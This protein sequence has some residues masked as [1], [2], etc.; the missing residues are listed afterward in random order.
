MKHIDLNKPLLLAFFLCI[1]MIIDAQDVY[2]VGSGIASIEPDEDFFSQSLQGYGDPAEG[3]F[4][5]NW[6]EKGDIE[7][8]N[9]LTGLGESLY[10]LRPGG[11]LYKADMTKDIPTWKWVAA[12]DTV[13]RLSGSDP[14]SFKIIAGLGDKLYAISL[15]NRLSVYD[16]TKNRIE[17][18]VIGN[19]DDAI[20]LTGTRAK[21]YMVTSGYELLEGLPKNNSM[22]WKKK[23]NV[24]ADILSIT[25]YEDRLYMLNSSQWIWEASLAEESVSWRKIAYLNGITYK[26][27]VSKL[28][29]VGNKLYAAGYD[30][31]IYVSRNET[32]NN[33]S[34]RALAI[35]SRSNTV[36]LVGVDLA[37]IDYS[38]GVEVKKEI[39][40]QTGIPAEAVMLNMS[41]S[42]FT[43]T[44]K[45]WIPFG[46][47]GYPDP[48]YMEKVKLSIVEA[49]QQ[50]VSSLTDSH[51]YFARTETYIGFNRSLGKNYSHINDTDVDILK[52]ENTEGKL[53][54][55]LFL[56]GCHPVFPNSGKDGFTISANYPGTA[57]D[58]IEKNISGSFSLFLQGCS[59]D[60]N[61]RLDN[62]E[63]L[64]TVLAFDVLKQLGKPSDKISGK[65]TY[66]LDSLLVPV[67]VWKHDKIESFRNDNLNKTGDI[68]AAK[69]I[70][71][72]DMM[73]LKYTT[74]SIQAFLPV[75]I[76]T[77]NIG[78]WK[79]VGLS[80]EP[81]SEYGIEIKKIWPNKKVSVA[82][83]NND[84]SSYLPTPNHMRSGTYEGYNSF[85]WYGEKAVFPENVFDLVIK[86]IKTDNR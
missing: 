16:T 30:G 64:G 84:V 51:I 21:L 13:F 40:R 46:D 14:N 45:L 49:V 73:L 62:Y 12:T 38:F 7:P 53:T 44:S 69:N 57:R 9:S 77:I 78:D 72:A 25:A 67:D 79:L 81:T 18:Q 5:L 36:V 55:V 68:E 19:V 48:R 3:R 41:H 24:P 22:E 27:P 58:I 2:K 75:Y 35:S 1:S 60:I 17:W 29:V 32:K 76:Q 10:S 28:A 82:G 20:A 59:G 74:D 71:W 63:T 54:N 85:F 6:I 37:A 8:S 66:S 15:N 47:F 11:D 34:A 31:K 52:I 50:A 43:P 23:G 61:P 33:I 70:R 4:T 42:H 83:Y 80:R 26:E 65:I 86:K 39:F 56:A